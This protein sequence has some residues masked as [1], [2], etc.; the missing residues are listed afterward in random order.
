MERE[1]NLLSI[2]TLRT[3]A[4]DAVE[5]AQSGHMGLPLGAAPMGYILWK[6]HLNINPNNPEWY[7]RDRFVLSAGHGS[8]LLYGL[9][10]LSGFNLS[11]EDIKD[12]RETGSKTPGHPEWEHTEGVEVTTGPLGQGIS[13][14]VGMA[15]AEKKLA[16]QFN[17]EDLKVIDYYTYVLCGDG[18]LMEGV[19][20][21]AISL[22]GH[23][24]LNKLIVLY[25]SNHSS[26]D[27]QLDASFSDDIK[28][29]FEAVHWNYIKVEDGTDVM[30]ID[31][32][33]VAAK[34]A[35]RPTLIEVNTIIGYGLP[36]IEGTHNAHSDPVGEENVKKAKEFYDWD[37]KK[38]FH[39]P[40]E[41]YA[42]FSVI[43][44]RG[45]EKE[46]QWKEKVQ[47]LEKD[48]PALFNDLQSFIQNRI[49]SSFKEKL[50]IFDVND[51]KIATRV[52]SHSVLNAVCKDI[53]QLIGGSADLSG[54]TKVSIDDSDRIT[55]D[56][57]SGRN[58]Y[59]G[60]RE[61]A[62]A[63]IANGLALNHFVPFVSTYFT[64]SD[65]MKPAIRLS[66]LMGL[67]V[68]Y[69]FTHDSIAVGKDGPTH[70][71][72]EQLAAFR[73]MPNITVIRPADGNETAAA[74]EIALDSKNKPTM[75]VLSRQ[76]TDTLKVSPEIVKEG[77]KKG[78][79]IVEQVKNPE[80]IIIATGSEVDL[81]LAVK[82]E[83][84][85]EEIFVNVVSLPSWELFEQQP[86]AYRL[87]VLPTHLT[88]RLSIEMG[89]KL[90]WKEYVGD[91]GK[92][93]SIDS[94]GISGEPTEVMEKF[95]FTLENA[96]KLYKS[97]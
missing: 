80:G 68:I 82:Q 22:A 67:P 76:A 14:A 61:F 17:Q 25:D 43:K 42:D 85:K 83:L 75:L 62:M 41:V 89:S 73:S 90:G 28:K 53:P 66:A 21:E 23:L 45:N 87:K 1:N 35:D 10:H 95:G 31:D 44:E 65:Y 64:F 38:D 27:E 48:D 2:N 33:I 57:F 24:N 36:D 60:V 94:F 86:E 70:Q 12:F 34:Q 8:M 97:I 4:I 30:S 84:E 18:D 19:S 29:K 20:H 72:I 79:Y 5:K 55:K 11:I 88:K 40:K 54:S 3:L 92:I 47:K 32:A 51:K 78:G 16:N 81:A 58:I 15:M 91:K 56:D 13:M 93:L 6:N 7:N 69:V 77:T 9:L 63:T 37:S 74:W 59:F 49:D 50:P 46:N 26:L 96:M 39:V 71:P 52:A